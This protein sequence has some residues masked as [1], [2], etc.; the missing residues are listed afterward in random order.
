MPDQYVEAGK[1]DEAEEIID[2]MFPSGDKAAGE[3]CDP[4]YATKSSRRRTL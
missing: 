2:V 1:L 4:A 3:G